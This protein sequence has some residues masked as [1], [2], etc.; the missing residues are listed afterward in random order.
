MKPAHGWPAC[1]Q[2][3]RDV[4]SGKEPP[5]ALT[6]DD[7]W[8]RLSRDESTVLWHALS[9]LLHV[10]QA[11]MTTTLFIRFIALEPEKAEQLRAARGGHYE[12]PSEEYIDSIMKGH[13]LYLEKVK[14]VLEGGEESDFSVEHGYPPSTADVQ[15]YMAGVK[16]PPCLTSSG[17]FARLTETESMALLAALYGRGAPYGSYTLFVERFPEKAKEFLQSQPSVVDKPTE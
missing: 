1:L 7:Y 15:D 8:K 16:P 2:D 14:R 13:V 9:G 3:Y 10:G 6:S 12:W 17:Y 11:E 5:A 4:M